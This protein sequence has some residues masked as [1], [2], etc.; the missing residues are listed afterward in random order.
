MNNMVLFTMG[1]MLRMV[2]YYKYETC[3][4]WKIS[5]GTFFRL[6]R[7]G[8]GEMGRLVGGIAL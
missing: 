2:A 3:M 1:G 6:L 7:G 4:L 5:T 8:F